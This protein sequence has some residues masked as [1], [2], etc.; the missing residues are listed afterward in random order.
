MKMNRYQRQQQLPEIGAGGQKLLGASRV[1]IVGC[2]A[3]GSVVAMYLAGAGV[4]EIVIADFDTLDVS[5]L[6][7]QVFYTEADTGKPKVELLAD[8]MRRLNSDITVVP[9]NEFIRPERLRQLAAQGDVVIEA[10]DNPD[11][12]YMV[13]DVCQSLDK[14]C[15]IGGVNGW[16]GQL[17]TCV[18]GG[19]YYRDVFAE[20]ACAGFTPCSLAGV[21]GPLPGT[22]ASLQAIEA[23]KILT[24][25]P[26]L[27]PQ[28]LL[29]DALTMSFSTI[30]L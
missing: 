9:V 3:L 13:S 15:V 11:T 22:I 17:L 29:F 19:K 8:R 16:Q 20:S 7:R 10:G 18:S 2:G 30:A 21:V 25:Q 27:K 12:K 4:G 26:A 6:H 5:N 24:R 1:V 14:P 23:I 28:L